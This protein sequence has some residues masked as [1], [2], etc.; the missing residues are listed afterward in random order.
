MAVA[1]GLIVGV[2]IGGMALVFI[3][4]AGKL[5][6]DRDDLQRQ[7]DAHH[8][9]SY[10]HGNCGA[11]AVNHAWSADCPVPRCPLNRTA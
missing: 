8:N 11:A 4:V 9:A 3:R 7:L 10:V 2:W 6:R 5:R 1:I